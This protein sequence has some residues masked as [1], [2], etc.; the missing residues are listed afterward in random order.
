MLLPDSDP[1]PDAAPKSAD[2]PQRRKASDSRQ[3][4]AASAPRA[5]PSTPADD[6]KTFSTSAPRD[7]QTSVRPPSAGSLIRL[8]ARQVSSEPFPSGAATTHR[9]GESG[10]SACA[11]L[12]DR[13]VKRCG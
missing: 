3:L 12:S 6:Q 11:I 10:A 7:T 1:S 4:E 5:L 2:P 9:V 8:G 13:V